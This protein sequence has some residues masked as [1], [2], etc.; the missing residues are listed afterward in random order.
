MRNL[1]L[2]LNLSLL[3]LSCA[4][5]KMVNVS[6]IK[7]V[8]IQQ[9]TYQKPQFYLKNYTPN[10]AS[11]DIASEDS[12]NEFI[13][14]SVKKLYFLTLWQQQNVF[15]KILGTTKRANSCP[16]FHN[17]LIKFQ[18]K[19]KSAKHAYSKEQN[20][21]SVKNS[22]DHII[23]Y[24]VLSLPYKGVDL[25][26]YLSQSQN[27]DNSKK[28]MLEALSVYAHDN[29]LEIENLCSKGVTDGLYIYQ[30]LTTYYSND[31]KFVR[32]NTALPSILKVKPVSN[33]LILNS[34]LKR[35][36]N[37]HWSDIQSAFLNKLNVPWFKNYLYEVTSMRNNKLTSVALKE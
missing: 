12:Q 13:S 11:R 28:H 36:L 14:L 26:S 18:D 31:Q 34:F 1:A 17:D 32:S 33:M 24:P 22:P 7:R 29:E 19:L 16:Q 27:W 4:T 37:Y 10:T 20:I 2:L 9:Q 15:N 3:L 35:D 21:L 5:H 23:F 8:E 30:N 6:G 25:Y